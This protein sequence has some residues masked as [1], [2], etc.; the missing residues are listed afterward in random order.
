MN[1]IP[2]SGW[3]RRLRLLC[4]CLA[5]GSLAFLLGGCST[6][7]AQ[8]S[9]ERVY[10]VVY[11]VTPHPLRGTAEVEL[12]VSQTRWYLRELSMQMPVPRYSRPAGDGEISVDG[13]QVTWL[14]PRDGGRL[15]WTVK[16]AN[17]RDGGSF[18]ARLEPDWAL[19]RATDIIP[20][21]HTRTMKG[22]RSNTQ[23]VFDL[24]RGWSSLTQ[25]RE[26][27]GRYPVSREGRRFDR[28]AGWILLGDIGVRFEDI[29]GVRV[30]IGGPSGQDVRR[31]D[32]LALLNWTLPSLT[33]LLP[34]FPDRLT[35]VS[36]SDRMWRGGLSGP[37][38]LYL[39]ADLP[40]LSENS[41]S[42]LLHEV[43]H[44]GTGLSARPGADWIV[45]GLAEYYGLE[46][47]RRSRT[48]TQA[49]FDAAIE[50]LAEWG[51]QAATLCTRES[52]AATTARAVA[53]FA[54]LREEL[55]EAGAGDPLD[56]V[57]RNLVRADRKVS[58]AQLRRLTADVHGSMP[59]ALDWSN[60]P[61][62]EAAD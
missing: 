29:A 7:T 20:P 26:R 38:S 40:L 24:P 28:P 32:M 59:A 19:F 18:D 47:L 35:I 9:P 46:I 1:C 45:E 36:A 27:R 17:Q 62:C 16:V 48:I 25:Y 33:R 6:A 44:I 39:H 52:T 22:A 41:T 30:L 61:G 8:D 21:A 57:L 12:A 55:R 51:Q 53:L 50:D 60:L 34:D 42:T 54:S 37:R 13:D 11:T 31:M 5:V 23:L 14:P 56:D 43:L 58:V 10:D 3:R 2:G 4:S 49:R 15:R